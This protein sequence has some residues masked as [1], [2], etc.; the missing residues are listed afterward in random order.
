MKVTY[1]KE[2]K[3]IYIELV[4]IPAGEVSSTEELV[5]DEVMID[6]FKNGTICGIELLCIESLEDTSGNPLISEEGKTRR[7]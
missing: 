7:Y 5:P 4:V 2:A 3:A 6:R 1:D